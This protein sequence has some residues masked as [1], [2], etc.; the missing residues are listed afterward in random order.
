MASSDVVIQDQLVHLTGPNA[1][2]DGQLITG[3]DLIVGLSLGKP[4]AVTATISGDLSVSGKTGIGPVVVPQRALHVH[5]SEIH[6]SGSA[7][8]FSFSD[9]GA[10]D[11]VEKPSKGERWVWYS[12]GGAAHLWSGKNLVTIGTSGFLKTEGVEASSLFSGSIAV[13]N[14]LQAGHPSVNITNNSISFMP[15]SS[16]ESLLEITGKTIRVQVPISTFA[17]KTLDLVQ[18]IQGLLTEVKELK[19]KVAALEARPR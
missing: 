10:S 1:L 11:F 15:P 4:K 13:K 8:G 14:L 7:A 19:A 9:R 17:T 5:G 18:E 2:V 16:T 6:S 3:G 12:Q